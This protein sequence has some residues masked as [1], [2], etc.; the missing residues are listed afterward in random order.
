MLT[1]LRFIQSTARQAKAAGLSPLE[2]ARAT[3]LGEFKDLLDSER[4]AGN[5]HRAYFELDGGERGAPV[6]F[7]RALGDMVAYN[8]GRPLACHA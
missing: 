4:I 1:Y 5:L 3:D 7:G 6:D 8:G 2:A